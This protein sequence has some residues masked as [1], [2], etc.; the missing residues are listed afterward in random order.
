MSKGLKLTDIL[1]TVVISV[2]LAAIYHF[3]AAV[4]E[5]AKAPGLQLEQLMY[6]MWFIASTVAFLLIRKP[7][8]AFLAEAAAASGE[9]LLGSPFGVEALTYGLVQGI[10]A[11]LLFAAT[12]YN[13]Y[14]AVTAGLAGMAA[15]AGALVFDFFKGYMTELQ[16]WSLVLYIVFRFVGA[17]VICGFVA[18]GLVKALEATGVAQLVRPASRADYDALNRKTTKM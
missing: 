3:W 4:Y 18:A 6:G 17:F 9:L 11:E 16:T 10:C 2:V 12:G 14:S 1:V 13:R 8:V 5:V 7:G 15:G